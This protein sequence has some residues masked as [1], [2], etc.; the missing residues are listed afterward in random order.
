MLT[1]RRFSSVIVVL[2]LLS[3]LCIP[4]T[5]Q[6]SRKFTLTGVA[7]AVVGDVVVVDTTAD[8]S[9]TLTTTVGHENVVGIAAEAGTP[10]TEITV[11]LCGGYASVVNVTGTVAAGDVLITSTTAGRARTA[12]DSESSSGFGFAT[13]DNPSGLGT[14]AALLVRPNLAYSADTDLYIDTLH[15]TGQITS[16]L[17]D[18]TAPLV[19]T[20]TTVNTNLNADLLDGNHAAAFQ[21]ADATLTALAGAGS[22][23]TFPY[24]TA[25][26]VLGNASITAAG[27][28]IL[29]DADAAAQRTTLGVGTGDSPN[30]IGASLGVNDV[31]AGGLTGYGNN[32]VTGFEE[33]LYNAANEDTNVGYW[34]LT[35]NGDFEIGADGTAKITIDDT[36]GA[37]TLAVD[38]ADSEIADTITAGTASKAT[39]LVGGNSTTLLG[40]MPYQS[41][42]DTTTLLGPNTSATKKFL[43]QTGT[44]TNGAAPA[45]DT[46]VAADVGNGLADAQVVDDLT[47]ESTHG[48]TALYSGVLT[49]SVYNSFIAGHTTSNDMVDGFGSGVLLRGTDPGGTFNFGMLQAVRDSADTEGALK[50][51]TGTNGLDLAL[52]IDH[53]LLATFVGAV[54]AASASNAINI[55]ASC[56]MTAP[57]AIGGVTPAAGAFTSVS[58]TGVL[59]TSTITTFAAND[60]T[61]TVAA[62]NIFVIPATWTAGNNITAFDNGVAGQQIV[63]IGGDPD[64]TVVN[65]GSL[66]LQG[67]WVGEAGYTLPLVFDG[68]SWRETTARMTATGGGAVM[69]TTP[70]TIGSVTPNTGK[71]TTLEA[72]GDLTLGG[73]DIIAST[74][75]TW[76]VLNTVATTVN[77][78][79]AAT[80]SV[81]CADGGAVTGNGTWTLDA[82][83]SPGALTL[84]Q[85]TGGNSLVVD[86]SGLVYDST[87]N[88]AG[89][90][91]ATPEYQVEILGAG[92][93][94][95]DLSD[96]GNVDAM[97]VINDSGT[98]ANTGGAIVFG[99]SGTK[100]IGAIKVALTDGT[101]NGKGNLSFLT[102]TLIGDTSL[103]EKV[104]ITPAGTLSVLLQGANIGSTASGADNDEV[105]VGIADAG[106]YALQAPTLYTSGTAYVQGGFHVGGTSDPGTD[107]LI[108]DG[109]ALISGKLTNTG[110]INFDTTLYNTSLG[111]DA[112]GPHITTGYWN[113]AVGKGAL[114]PNTTGNYNTAVGYLA[115]NANQTNSG[116]TAVG[117]HALELATGDENVCIGSSAGYKITTGSYNMIFGGAGGTVGEEITTGSYNLAIGYGVHV[118]SPTAN[119]QMNIAGLITG[120]FAAGDPA[121]DTL[122]LKANTTVQGSLATSTIITFTANDTSPSVVGANSFAVPASGWTAGQNVTALD[123]G[124]V[125]QEIT[126][127]GGDTDCVITDGGTLYIV[128]NWTS[129]SHAM[130]KLKCVA[131]NTW[132]ELCRS[133]P[134]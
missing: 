77:A 37:V 24:F 48:I 106:A 116:S 40:S 30:F 102:R 8:E 16:T 132:V 122:V 114:H 94:S 14:V 43:R 34:N 60:T 23:N 49:N 31:T 107:N 93:A 104:R 33:K 127:Y 58:A 64:C 18:G 130:I 134:G 79:G 109:T 54:T 117:D 97:L 38:L 29:D 56:T 75:T 91:D 10:A 51:Y 7:S 128:G 6:M 72:T 73:G 20:S 85:S 12:T 13:S 21:A 129:A 120:T 80:T 86:T 69:W 3:V 123:F 25:T 39:N 28:A 78:F 26:D 4:A 36:T 15:V 35:A 47:I 84:S 101:S 42:V 70:G 99:A 92:Q 96:A 110:Y 62:G 119:A 52:T 100:T 45:W 126:I 118:A 112:V 103:T 63:V 74:A 44:G 115:L 113:T 65:G 125:G 46:I 5:A 27:L 108:V 133:A 105:C 98:G 11:R 59:K 41:D 83:S 19:V 76:N 32:D 82:I 2:L 88:R 87:N 131:A 55:G 68:A 124:I 90:G 61:P 50:F 1:L 95:A 121:T 67:D 17:A 9:V 66:A 53:N 111:E 57:P 22:A 71:F 81:F 89:F